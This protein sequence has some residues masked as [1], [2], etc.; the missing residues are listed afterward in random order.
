MLQKIFIDIN[1]KKIIDVIIIENTI[2]Y[3]GNIDEEEYDSIVF[4]RTLQRIL[5]A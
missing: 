2:I 5:I 1:Y 4:F 3:P